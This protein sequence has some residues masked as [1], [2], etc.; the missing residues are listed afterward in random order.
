M[1]LPSLTSG[2][3]REKAIASCSLSIWCRR[4]SD[5]N[6]CF[7]DVTTSLIT[8]NYSSSDFLSNVNLLN[9]EA[10]ASPPVG[11]WSIGDPY[12]YSSYVY[13]EFTIDL[14]SFC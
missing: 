2:M 10:V 14:S 1:M 5:N 12:E 7:F 9:I 8:E 6:S 11:D 4:H 3:R 13:T